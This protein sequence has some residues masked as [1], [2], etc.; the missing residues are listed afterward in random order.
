MTTQTAA[1]EPNEGEI[2]AEMRAHHL[3][4]KSGIL[5]CATCAAYEAG[6]QDGFLAAFDD[7]FA[8]LVARTKP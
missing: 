8:G 6:R 7:R 1:P 4:C 5:V 2:V 3:K